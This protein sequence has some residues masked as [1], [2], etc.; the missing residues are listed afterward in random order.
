MQLSDPLEKYL[1]DSVGQPGFQGQPIRMV[2][3]AN[4]TSGLPRLPENIFN[5][6]VDPQ[7]PYLHYGIDSLF[8]YLKHYQL[9]EKPGHQF[10]Y[11]N[12]GAGLL[13]AILE[14]STGASFQH[15]IKRDITAPLKMSS[16]FITVPEKRKRDLA[17]GYNERG[18]ET[19]RWDLASLQGSG[20]I[21][22]T[23]TDMVSYIKAQ[24]GKDH[25]LPG[26]LPLATC[27]PSKPISR[28]WP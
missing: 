11:S 21:A 16:T 20:A 1:P 10:S 7:N 15:L 17:I 19:S 22:S 9:K 18:L 27:P 12:Y 2:H 8:S 25:H 13:G 28:T 23:L 26:Q 24:L 5:G 3:L 6:N 14:I 4:H